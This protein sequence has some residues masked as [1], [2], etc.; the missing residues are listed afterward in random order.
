MKPFLD[1]NGRKLGERNSEEW[2]E[3]FVNGAG[4][5]SRDG[6]LRDMML[7]I[8]VNEGL[9]ESILHDREMMK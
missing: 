8:E 4:H 5:L 3:I 2:T 9:H 7:E 6:Q 1:L